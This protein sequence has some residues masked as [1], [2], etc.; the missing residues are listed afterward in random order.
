MPRNVQI[1]SR[2]S[3]SI[4]LSWDIPEDLGNR[5]DISYTLWYQEV[6]ASN[7]INSSRVV[8]ATVG[9]INGRCS[10]LMVK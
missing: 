10:E 1:V 8:N 3:N 2:T 4:T 5:S 7:R 6:G 9:T